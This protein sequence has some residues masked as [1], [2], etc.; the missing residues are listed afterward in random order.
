MER[1]LHRLAAKAGIELAPL[2]LPLERRLQTF[3]VLFYLNCVLVIPTIGA[4]LLVLGLWSRF[5]MLSVGYLLWVIYDMAFAKTHKRGGRRS[6][7]MREGRI[8]IW[9][10]DYFPITLEKTADFG[11]GKNYILGI[12]PHGI[13]GMSNL[14]NFGS[15]ATGWSLKYPGI[16]SH[17]CTL[18]QNLLLPFIRG[19]LMWLGQF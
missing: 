2:R 12:H 8:P 15:E 3:G 16:T 6:Q 10:R 18:S 17:V 13:F 11:R 14:I 1:A 5:Y 4:I 9:I 7:W 19:Y